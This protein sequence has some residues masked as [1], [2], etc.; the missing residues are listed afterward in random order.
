MCALVQLWVPTELIWLGARTKWECLWGSPQILMYGFIPLEVSRCLHK[1]V[2]G[3]E[4]KKLQKSE[5]TWCN[6]PLCKH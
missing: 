5:C 2:C 4:T 1:A 6:V 3:M